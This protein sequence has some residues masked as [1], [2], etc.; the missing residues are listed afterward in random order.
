[1]QAA[2]FSAFL[3]SGANSIEERR[4]A[5]AR[6]ARRLDESVAA[7]PEARHF[8]IAH[9]HG[10]NVALNARQIMS[11]N[12]VNVH[13]VTLATPFLS[14]YERTPRITDRLFAIGVSIGLVIF[15][16]YAWISSWA[17]GA[18]IEVA[19]YVLVSANC[20]ISLLS[21]LFGAATFFSSAFQATWKKSRS[22][23]SIRKL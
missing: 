16:S 15:A 4:S 14:I 8:I 2:D 17:I 21:I 12:T 10:G 1:V 22:A 6:L 7:A 23:G 11:G 9:S 5:A 20:L 3:W 13:I 19:V 18:P